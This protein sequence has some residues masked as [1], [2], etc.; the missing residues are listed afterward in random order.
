MRENKSIDAHT[1]VVGCDSMHEQKVETT[2]PA[3]DKK[4]D[5]C[6][7]FAS[8]VVVLIVDV[9]VVVLLVV[10]VVVFTVVA[11]LL[12]KVIVTVLGG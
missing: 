6:F 4:L 10:V 2:A 5:H 11:A 3:C 9:V 1:Y 7:A 12:F 8:A